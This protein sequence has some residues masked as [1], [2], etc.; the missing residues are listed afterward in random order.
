MHLE[1]LL[2]LP[3][4][5]ARRATRFESNY[6]EEIP[7]M[8]DCSPVPDVGPFT[9]AQPSVA[10]IAGFDHRFDGVG[11]G[12]GDDAKNR[13]SSTRLGKSLPVVHLSTRDFARENLARIKLSA[14]DPVQKF[15]NKRTRSR[16]SAEPC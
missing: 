8:Q 3:L 11:I 7:C 12:T 13:A 9:R 5:T 1:S 16:C 6:E 10:L 15:L 2:A 4:R 14:A